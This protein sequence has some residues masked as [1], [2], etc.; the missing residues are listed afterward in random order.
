[1][2]H[3]DRRD[4][5]PKDYQFGDAAKSMPYAVS[6]YARLYD[7][8]RV[9]IGSTIEIKLPKRYLTEAQDAWM[10]REGGMHK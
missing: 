6:A 8:A 9:Q 10:N 4:P 2:S 3:Q 1:M 5:L 7:A